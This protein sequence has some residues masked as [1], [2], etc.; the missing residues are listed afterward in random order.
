MRPWPRALLAVALLSAGTLLA[1]VALTRV[2]AIAQG[3]HFAFLVISLALLGFGASGT[4]LA[5]APRLGEPRLW[6]WHAAAYGALTAGAF[7]FIDTFPFDPYLV[8]RQGTELL[9][10]FA[11]LVALALPFL[12]SGLLIGSMLSRA[13]EQAGRIYGANLLGSGVGAAMGP[14]I[15]DVLGSERAVIGAGALGAV[16]ALALA[17]APRGGPALALTC[18]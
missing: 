12:F 6:P 15:L 9:L 14:V 5:V 11:D 17:I 4:L 1:Q 7:F 13:A 8:A 3:Y 18:R 10:L 2:L 16:A